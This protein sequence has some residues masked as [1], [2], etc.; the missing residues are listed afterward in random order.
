LNEGFRYRDLET[1]VWLSRDPAGFVDGPNLYAYV[2]QNPWTGFDPDGLMTWQEAKGYAGD[3]FS[4]VGQM[5]AGYGDVTVGAVASAGHAVASLPRNVNSIAHSLADISTHDLGTLGRA[6][7]GA[8]KEIGGNVSQAASDFGGRLAQGDERTWGQA[9]GTA[10]TLGGAKG[11]QFAKAA[12]VSEATEVSASAASTAAKAEQAAAA[13]A[14]EVNATSNAG[15]YVKSNTPAVQRTLPKDKNGILQPDVDV[16]HTQLGR[17]TK[18][19]GSE[20]QA[21]EWM[22]DDKG[23]L[24]PTRDIDFTDHNMPSIHP[25]PHQHTLTPTNQRN[26]VGGGFHRGDPELLK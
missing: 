23:R 10:L 5:W 7:V 21:R 26:P 18:S 9:V 14:P 17:S 8:G 19:H 6:G 2:K 13:V 1:G 15:A 24:V 11:A 16:P 12:P 20:P 4:G 22:H 25:N 3:W